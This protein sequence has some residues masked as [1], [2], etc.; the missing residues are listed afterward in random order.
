MRSPV[1][2]NHSKRLSWHY[3]PL[4]WNSFR[5]KVHS[6]KKWSPHFLGFLCVWNLL[7]IQSTGIGYIRAE[8]TFAHYFARKI[9]LKSRSISIRCLTT[10]R[11]PIRGFAPKCAKKVIFFR[12]C[13]FEPSESLIFS[14]G[15][16]KTHQICGW[17]SSKSEVNALYP[18]GS[19]MPKVPQNALFSSTIKMV[20]KEISPVTGKSVF[21]HSISH[22]LSWFITKMLPNSEEMISH[23]VWMLAKL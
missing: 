18:S 8:T 9:A 3:R 6:V 5:L 16:G 1:V 23:I 20:L 13:F 21:A 4:N 14:R 17:F 12:N 2:R 15:F 19:E 11:K 22:A 10:L 7:Q